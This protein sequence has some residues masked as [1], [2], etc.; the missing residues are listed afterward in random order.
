VEFGRRRGEPGFLRFWSLF[1]QLFAPVDAFR[2]FVQYLCYSELLESARTCHRLGVGLAF[3]LVLLDNV[4]DEMEAGVRM[5]SLFCAAIFIMDRRAMTID[6]LAALFGAETAQAIVNSLFSKGVDGFVPNAG[7]R[8]QLRQIE[9]F[10][11][12][13]SRGAIV[14]AVEP[15]L[16]MQRIPVHPGRTDAFLGAVKRVR[17][18]PSA[19][20][21]LEETAAPTSKD[22]AHRN[23][24]VASDRTENPTNQQ[25]WSVGRTFARPADAAEE[26][27]KRAA[28]GAAVCE[29]EIEQ[30]LLAAGVIQ[31]V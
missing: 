13:S 4:L 28:S 6:R 1:G 27:L 2:L 5:F 25:F 31:S 22:C 7:A 24:M 16:W 9:V 19:I 30:M 29:I 12:V 15:F 8:D 23:A 20:F 10:F 17:A 11:D 3:D 18:R 21:V 14:A 26:I